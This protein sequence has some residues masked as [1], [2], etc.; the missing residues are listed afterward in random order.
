MPS[1]AE[2]SIPI[3]IE[4]FPTEIVEMNIEPVYV[5]CAVTTQLSQEQQLQTSLLQEVT[6]TQLQHNIESFICDPNDIRKI[7]GLSIK[8]MKYLTMGTWLEGKEQALYDLEHQYGINAAFAM[9]VSTL[10]SGSGSSNRA[11]NRNSFYGESTGKCYANHYDNT[12]YFGDFMSRLYINSGKISVDTIGPKYCP[13]NRKWEIF[14]RNYMTEKEQFVRFR[15][16]Q[17]LSEL[18]QSF[19]SNAI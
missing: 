18:K 1:Y 9:G 6:V 10:E 7:T 14:V 15:L 4:P 3:L 8:D 11:R 12:M 17:K 16:N 19:D 2:E 13:P 5:D